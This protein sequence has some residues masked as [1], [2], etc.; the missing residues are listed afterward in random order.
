MWLEVGGV[1]SI[2]RYPP[3]FYHV[4]TWLQFEI[5]GIR[6]DIDF[7][8]TQY[9]VLCPKCSSFVSDADRHLEWHKEIKDYDQ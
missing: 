7:E 8:E 2:M 1:E 3:N 4:E 9:F 6:T 5:K